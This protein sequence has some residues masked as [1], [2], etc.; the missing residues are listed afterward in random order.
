MDCNR[1][2]NCQAGSSIFILTTL[3]TH[4]LFLPL[5]EPNLTAPSPTQL[6]Q[7]FCRLHSTCFKPHCY[8][9]PHLKE[10]TPVVITPLW[11]L[12][13]VWCSTWLYFFIRTWIYLEAGMWKVLYSHT[14]QPWFKSVCLCQ[15]SQQSAAILNRCLWI[16]LPGNKNIFYFVTGSSAVTGYY[17]VKCKC[18]FYETTKWA[19][20][21]V[22][23]FDSTTDVHAHKQWLRSA[24]WYNVCLQ[25]NF[26]F[27]YV[28]NC[29]SSLEKNKL[30]S[31]ISICKRVPPV[32]GCLLWCQLNFSINKPCIAHSAVSNELIHST[33]R[34]G[35]EANNDA[36]LS[37]RYSLLCEALEA[38]LCVNAEKNL[39]F[40]CVLNPDPLR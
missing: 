28:A 8:P 38:T 17:R 36:E 7:L 14:L 39:R 29:H 3:I 31:L 16:S 11:R 35:H 6:G 40:L 32:F 5:R 33:N 30:L 20:I 26:P 27:I 12:N 9:T 37:G 2:Q 22:L 1:R 34:R 23:S 10:L 4:F 25:F 24:K 19:S 21:Q 13:K 18:V 15:K